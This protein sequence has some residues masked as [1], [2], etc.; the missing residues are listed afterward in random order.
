[1]VGKVTRHLQDP[2]LDTLVSTALTDLPGLMCT[3]FC[4]CYPNL[5]YYSG[6]SAWA[7]WAGTSTS[8]ATCKSETGLEN[9]QPIDR[10]SPPQLEYGFSHGPD[11]PRQ[12]LGRYVSLA[13][14]LQACSL[15]RGGCRGIGWDLICTSFLAALR[16]LPGSNVRPWNHS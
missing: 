2:L 16:P 3:P 14:S 9:R 5:C 12:L 6:A 8:Q 1:M 11:R 4:I 15:E 13:I 10:P 7:Q